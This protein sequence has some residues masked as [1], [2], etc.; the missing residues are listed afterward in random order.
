MK[1]HFEQ[2]AI[3]TSVEYASEYLYRDIAVPPDTLFIS[4]S[5]SGETADTL[6]ALEKAKKDGRY[7]D[8]LA[9]CNVP[10]SALTRAANHTNPHP[11]RAGNRRRLDQSLRHPARRTAPGERHH[12]RRTRPPLRARTPANLRPP[13]APPTTHPRA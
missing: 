10:E 11:R 2:N 3:P 12:R 13:A 6:A 4:L 5:Q 8:N 9:I 7:H 1:Y